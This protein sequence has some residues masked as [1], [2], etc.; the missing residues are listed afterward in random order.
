MSAS[1]AITG[2]GTLFKRLTVPISEI[3]SIS[4]PSKSRETIEVTRLE[5]SDGYRQYI[6]GL[7]NPGTVTLNMNFTAEGYAAMNTDF[8]SN[9]A[10]SYS[11]V[12]PDGC[13]FA[14]TGLVTELPVTIPIGDK[15]TMDVTIQ[16]SGKVTFTDPA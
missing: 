5:D 16:V 2:Q 3:N 15:V 8:E 12:L 6:G 9:S 10:V 13:T 14:F 4:G 7:R 1:A 11:I